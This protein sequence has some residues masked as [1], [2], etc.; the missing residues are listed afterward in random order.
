MH[1]TYQTGIYILSLAASTLAIAQER[2]AIPHGPDNFYIGTPAGWVQPKTPWGDPD[3]QGIYPENFVGSVLMQRCAGRQRPGAPPCDPH[4]AFLTEEEFKAAQARYAKAPDR[5]EQAKQQGQTGREFL[6][7]VTD[8][9]PPQRQT[10]FIFDP[11]DGKFPGLTPE[12]KRVGATMGTSWAMHGEHL[13]FNSYHDF[14]VKD[15]CITHGMPASMFPFH[16][17]N[18]IQIF[19][20]PGEVVLFLEMIHEVRIIPLND[21]QPVP[22]V[23]Q[24][25]LG[26]SHGH[27]EGNTLVV[28]T[29]NVKPGAMMINSA[30][31][32]TPQEH[33]PT[34]DRMK[35]AERFTRINDDYL[36]YEIKTEDPVMLTHS[37]TARMPWK[38]DQSYKILEYACHEDNHIVPD[39]ISASRAE[40]K[41]ETAA[42]NPAAQ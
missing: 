26:F 7:G 18:G 38:R 31:P 12:G 3:I 30:M 35:I 41:A 27:W 6:R 36:I 15:L 33:T 20:A 13:V 32:G 23:V 2:P 4:K 42:K 19:Q 34:S 16:Y 29:T 8:P 17:N 24:D 5:Y 28:E 37:W 25:W 14:D 40:R 11:P 9:T 21:N 1:A 10:A 22:N 39:W